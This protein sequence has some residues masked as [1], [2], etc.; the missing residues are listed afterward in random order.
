MVVLVVVREKVFVGWG[1]KKYLWCCG[2]LSEL[3]FTFHVACGGEHVTNKIC[4]TRAGK[5]LF[6]L[7]IHAICTQCLNDREP[8]QRHFTISKHVHKA[9]RSK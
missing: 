1:G 3:R 7:Y 9:S 2:G 5:P 8:F 6:E 4:L